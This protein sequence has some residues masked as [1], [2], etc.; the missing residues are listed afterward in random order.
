MYFSAPVDDSMNELHQKLAVLSS[1]LNNNIPQQQQGDQQQQQPQ[2]FQSQQISGTAIYSP[3]PTSQLLPQQEPIVSQ[4]VVDSTTPFVHSQHQPQQSHHLQMQTVVVNN[5]L[6]LGNNGSTSGSPMVVNVPVVNNPAA[7]SSSVVAP[8]VVPVVQTTYATPPTSVAMHNSN[9]NNNNPLLP[10]SAP[11]VAQHP[12]LVVNANQQTPVCINSTPTVMNH[13][14]HHH[15]PHNHLQHHHQHPIN[16]LLSSNYSTPT[17][18]IV[19]TNKLIE[20]VAN[21]GPSGAVPSVSKGFRFT[22]VPQVF[23]VTVRKGGFLKRLCKEFADSFSV[24]MIN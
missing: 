1:S 17:T 24:Q 7:G 5:P 19:T 3:A 6:S 21:Q 9:I 23:F 14:H 12:S 10:G 15:V 2:Q 22:W 18:T 13:Q 4:M 20:A 16:E 8:T 11:V